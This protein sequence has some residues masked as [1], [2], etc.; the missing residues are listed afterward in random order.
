MCALM[1]DSVGE[2]GLNPAGVMNFL[3]N[4]N[5]E[6]RERDGNVVLKRRRKRVRVRFTSSRLMSANNG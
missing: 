3:K 6:K 5:K 1:C 2:T 4:A